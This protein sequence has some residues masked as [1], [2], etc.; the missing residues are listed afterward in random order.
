M[1][2]PASDQRRNAIQFPEKTGDYSAAVSGT[3]AQ[4]SAPGLGTSISPTGRAPL[5][6]TFKALKTSIFLAKNVRLS[7]FWR[8]DAAHLGTG[9]E[10]NLHAA[11]LR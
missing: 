11:K 8:A 2:L 1:P 9:A 6:A 4:I 10:V 7:D 3:G 5:P